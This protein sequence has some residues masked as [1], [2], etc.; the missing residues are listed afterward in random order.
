L[1]N[2]HD[3]AD[4]LERLV[5]NLLEMT[6]LEAG[7]VRLQK[8]LHHPGEVIGSAIARMEEKLKGRTLT[9]EI[10]ESLPLVPMDP[11]L[12]EQV[13]VNLLDNVV[14]YTPSDSPVDIL[15]LV[16]QK[17]LTVEVMDRGPGVPEEDL[18]RLF[19]K[20]YR[21]PQKDKKNGAG[22]GLSIC[23]GIIDIHGG[24]I[25][26]ENRAGGGSR[27]LFTLPLSLLEVTHE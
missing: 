23:K 5:S 27:F 3:E 12:I 20:F 16:D 18:P 17:E 7:A 24:K 13:L 10:P 4:R 22:L 2:I 15:V 14:K 6:K 1:E 11:L 26:A 8:E 9:T 19:E 21:V 25:W